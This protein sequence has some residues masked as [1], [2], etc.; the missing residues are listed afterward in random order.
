MKKKLITLLTCLLAL[1]SLTACVGIRSSKTSTEKKQAEDYVINE[2]RAEKA[3]NFMYDWIDLVDINVYGT[4]GN[5]FVE[6]KPKDLKASDFESDS[7]YM[8]IKTE[9]EDLNLYYV[10]DG[11]DNSNQNSGI[12]VDW[13]FNL[14]S[15]NVITIALAEEEEAFKGQSVYRGEYEYK[16]GN[17]KETETIDLFSEDNI[18]FYGLEETGEVTYYIPENSKLREVEGLIDNISYKITKDNS[19]LAVDQTILSIEATINS[20]YLQEIGYST[21]ALY[22]AKE[23]YRTD[24]FTTQLV[25]HNLA[26]VMDFS[27][28]ELANE[29]ISLLEDKITSLEGSEG[30]GA[31]NFF[32]SVCSIQKLN[33]DKNDAYAYYV[34]YRDTNSEGNVNYLRRSIR[35]VDLNNRALLLSIGG[36]ETSNESFAYDAYTDGQIV[37]SNYVEEVQEENLEEDENQEDAAPV[38]DE[39]TEE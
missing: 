11:L 6:I 8:A 4:N 37:Y 5:A 32:S 28:N 12:T 22:L 13:A 21:F 35:L 34:I 14:S 27:N 10:G 31:G 30:D 26:R 25:L 18:T 23:G 15:G 24:N 2:D 29:A 7:D 36:Q 38:Q 20:K 1:T 3:A 16:V 9:V 39:Q 33:K 19:N 17:L